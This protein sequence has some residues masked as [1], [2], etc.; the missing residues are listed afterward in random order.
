MREQVRQVPTRMRVT[1]GVARA[2]RVAGLGFG[3]A[4]AARLFLPADV[5]SIDRAHAIASSWVC[6]GFFGSNCASGALSRCATESDRGNTSAP[7][8]SKAR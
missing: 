6:Y 4:C 8:D 5:S 1:A 2:L 7:R 3:T